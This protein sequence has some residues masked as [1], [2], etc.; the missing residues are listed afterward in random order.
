MIT[1][2]NQIN[3]I[4]NVGV[5]PEQKGKTKDGNPVTC[6]AIAQSVS[7]FDHDTGVRSQ[8]EPQWFKVSCFSNLA[9][10]AFLNLKKG[11]LVLVTGELKARTYK[12]V[13]GDKKAGFEVIASDVLKVQRLSSKA[14]ITQTTKQNEEA[15][16]GPLFDDWNGEAMES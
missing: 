12:T 15:V 6:F 7:T 9:N 14:N 1:I 11:D 2:N 5:D 3:L 4:G 13:E 16:S 8:Q 10:R